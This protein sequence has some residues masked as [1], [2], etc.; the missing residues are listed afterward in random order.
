MGTL[1]RPA[2]VFSLDYSVNSRTGK[3]AHPTATDFSSVEAGVA[4]D[5]SGLLGPE[6]LVEWVFA[7]GP[8]IA[9]TDLPSIAAP[10]G[11][12]PIGFWLPLIALGH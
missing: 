7:F 4:I 11:F 12:R 8:T 6:Q 9:A 5:I 2:F 10:V 3:S 1:A